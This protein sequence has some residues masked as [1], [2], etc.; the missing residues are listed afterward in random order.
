MN[1]LQ[2]APEMDNMKSYTLQ[3]QADAKWLIFHQ[4]FT[5]TGVWFLAHVAATWYLITTETNLAV[6][7]M[8]VSIA[9][10]IWAIVLMVRAESNARQASREAANEEA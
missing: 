5:A 3:A 2:R 8:V 4:A 6:G 1:A 9:F 7:L 10:L